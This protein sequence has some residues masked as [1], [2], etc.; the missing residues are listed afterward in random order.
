MI[1]NFIDR[2]RSINPLK[3]EMINNNIM[4]EKDEKK[5]QALKDYRAFIE[6]SNDLFTK[7]RRACTA[8]FNTS[9]PKFAEEY[10]VSIIS[11]LKDLSLMNEE[12]KTQM[13]SYYDEI[14]K[15]YD[16][17]IPTL[18][19]IVN[20]KEFKN[21][22][23]SSLQ[24]RL[25]EKD[26]MY[27]DFVKAASISNT[28][29]SKKPNID[30]NVDYGKLDLK[31]LRNR[32]AYIDSLSPEKKEAYNSEVY[33][34]TSRINDIRRGKKVESQNV[35]TPS[36]APSTDNKKSST[37]DYD[38]DVEGNY[39]ANNDNQNIKQDSPVEDNNNNKTFDGYSQLLIDYYNNFKNKSYE[40]LTKEILDLDENR[41][42]KN[43]YDRSNGISDYDKYQIITGI[44]NSRNQT[45]TDIVSSSMNPNLNDNN[46][47]SIDYSALKTKE[48]YHI[49]Q[50][51]YDDYIAEGYE[52][53]TEDF[54]KAVIQDGANTINY[55]NS[56]SFVDNNKSLETSGDKLGLPG[57]IQSPLGLP[58]ET[59]SP[60]GLP[61]KIQEPLGLPGEVQK[62]KDP[63]KPTIDDKKSA[64]E[65]I[66]RTSTIVSEL[67]NGLEFGAKDGRHYVASKIKVLANTKDYIN[68][69]DNGWYK[70]AAVIP[71]VVKAPG[72][73][74]MKIIGNSKF[75][76]EARKNIDELNRRL[77]EME[78]N[79]DDPRWK[80]LAEGNDYS[81]NFSYYSNTLRYPEIVNALFAEHIKN[82]YRHLVSE[83]NKKITELYDKLDDIQAKISAL[84]E[85]KNDSNARVIDKA[86]NE[87]VKGT[88][89]DIIEI[90][91]LQ[92]ENEKM[93]NGTG[94]ILDVNENVK[95]SN[96]RMSLRGAR[97]AKAK[98][99][100][101]N[102]RLFGEYDLKIQDALVSGKELEAFTNFMERDELLT[103]ESQA[104][105]SFWGMVQNGD[106]NYSRTSV[107][108]DFRDDP[109]IRDLATTAT[110]IGSA[111]A[112]ISSFQKIVERNNAIN[113]DNQAISNV[114]DQNRKIGQDVNAQG[115]QIQTDARNIAQGQ[116]AQSNVSQLGMGGFNSRAG[117]DN[118]K[119]GGQGGWFEDPSR[120]EEVQ[121]GFDEITQQGKAVIE[122]MAARQESMKS[123][124]SNPN[125]SAKEILQMSNENLQNINADFKSFAS[126]Y[127]QIFDFYSTHAGKKF[128]LTIQ[129]DLIDRV[130]DDQE[131]LK[132]FASSTIKVEEIGEKLMEFS[133]EFASVI[134]ATPISIAPS[135]LAASSL[136]ALGIAQ[137][138]EIGSHL[139]MS[140]AE[141]DKEQ[142][143]ENAEKFADDLLAHPE[144]IEGIASKS[145]TKTDIKIDNIKDQK[146]NSEVINKLLDGL[147]FG[148]KDGKYYSGSNIKVGRNFINRIVANN[149]IWYKVAATTPAFM[150]ILPSGVVKGISNLKLTQEA[151]DNI[152]KLKENLN[153][154]TDEEIEALAFG[155]D[156]SNTFSC[157]ANVYRLPSVVVGLV[158]D[159][160]NEYLNKRVEAINDELVK[161]YSEI[162]NTMTKINAMN[163]LLK[164]E[165]VKPSIKAKLSEDMA[166]IYDGK[167]EVIKRIRK[168]Q[169]EAE[170]LLNGSGIHAVDENVK[171]AKTR[172][173]IVGCRFSKAKGSNG[174][175]DIMQTIGEWNDKEQ[176]ALET[177]NDKEA[178][179]YFSMEAEKLAE[180]SKATRTLFGYVNKGDANFNIIAS[181]R[182]FNDDPFVKDVLSTVTT[183]TAIYKMGTTISDIIA[184]KKLIDSK[185]AELQNVNDANKA[186]SDELHASGNDIRSQQSV[187]AKYAE[188]SARVTGDTVGPA[189][190]EEGL[191]RVDSKFATNK[192]EYQAYD[193]MSTHAEISKQIEQENKKMID[194]ISNGAKNGSIGPDDMYKIATE[195]YDRNYGYL[196]EV[197]KDTIKTG[198]SVS[199]AGENYLSLAQQITQ[200]KS[201]VDNMW[202]SLQNQQ[203]IGKALINTNLVSYQEL[204]ALPN[205]MRTALLQAV[206]GYVTVAH[207]KGQLAPMKDVTLEDQNR[208]L[209]NNFTNDISQEEVD[210]IAD[211]ILQG[212]SMEET[213]GNSR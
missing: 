57:E 21:S 84:K 154:L 178:F 78:G 17:Y 128:D 31:D 205:D 72:L 157:Y 44:I 24:V 131:I 99:T 88:S 150:G 23:V 168:N 124:L 137:N 208:A 18:S 210:A 30:Q 143:K 189:R 104:T 167:C 136:Y 15:E 79:F 134:K 176:Y 37:N 70:A 145:E 43:L 8:R 80:T 172:L 9:V 22:P 165:D 169:M 153:K 193:K 170:K 16:F 148:A 160:I 122:K 77:T 98:G 2:I 59:Q 82:Y 199:T 211:Q 129:K 187:N 212:Y 116:Q 55:P 138:K 66:L 20:S 126:T 49:S 152:D 1:E 56:K 181:L 186:K 158:A 47:K 151:R 52:P 53:G 67:C 19:D 144:K 92:T 101:E 96:T 107:A 34:I 61:G 159:K 132:A 185:N 63:D 87:L 12:L 125:L 102:Q 64:S 40:E 200:N 95:A 123:A 69:V 213:H 10:E 36:T 162:Y 171:A 209:L 177:N 48:D 42:Y 202:S 45:K 121:K 58:G 50:E 179:K 191:A 91:K 41:S 127:K 39:Q 207:L 182:N 119:Y 194:T 74:V 27:D 109:F 192:A 198:K 188:H 118:N 13:G 62:K 135:V 164:R 68:K 201:L 142:E 183:I 130:L 139:Q 184:D 108:R 196:M 35:S 11:Y 71:A 103:K 6:K 65:H 133:P 197:C 4:V 166:H 204:T 163:M 120:F 94:G 195:Q 51:A 155:N 81:A 114:S 29:L 89:S 3:I 32:F 46:K 161:D 146:V 38:V 75:S 100:N 14:T 60:L 86:I 97:F 175:D 110:T 105:K 76:E 141:S 83:N 140:I 206:M 111:A 33:Q 149:N 28:N 115:Q 147:T 25:D 112:V 180:E 113:A 26:K 85:R 203:D 54:Y 190:E 106:A 156:R 93:L 173:S 7:L 174:K 5:L 117:Y 73:E 90:L